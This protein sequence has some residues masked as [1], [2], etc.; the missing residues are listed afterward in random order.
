MV[1]TLRRFEE[2]SHGT[3]GVLM[4]NLNLPICLT[5]ELPFVDNLK[6]VSCIPEGVYALKR[7]ASPTHGKVYQVVGVP[8]RAGILLHPANLSSQLRGCIAPGRAFGLV[9]LQGVTGWGVLESKTACK[10]LFK[11]LDGYA[12]NELI[13]RRVS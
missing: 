2:N 5:L 8:N 3:F 12:Q 9:E 1:L 10:E 13:I 7:F 11:L 4:N 6:G